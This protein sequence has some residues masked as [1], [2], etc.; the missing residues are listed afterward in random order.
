MIV[1][2][3]LTKLHLSSPSSQMKHATQCLQLI[4]S[5]GVYVSSRARTSQRKVHS[6]MIHLCFK[7]RDLVTSHRK[8]SRYLE[9]TQ[10]TTAATTHLHGIARRFKISVARLLHFHFTIFISNSSFSLFLFIQGNL[11]I[12]QVNLCFSRLVT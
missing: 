11:F 2:S 10:H 3:S 4:H 7:L 5:Q 9:V 8:L 6:Q 12:S 1:T